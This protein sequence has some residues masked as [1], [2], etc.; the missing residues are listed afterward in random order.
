MNALVVL[1]AFLAMEPITY[2]A[3]RWVMHGP[4]MRLHRSHHLPPAGRLEA[5]DWFPVIFA[6]VVGSMMAIGFNVDGASALVWI[7]IGVT[8]YGATYALVHDG[9]IHHRLPWIGARRRRGFQPLAEA[10]ELH[11]RFGGEPYGMLLPVVPR[12]VRARAAQR[13]TAR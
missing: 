8:L 9:Y 5:N 6:L 13:A 3:H 1:G 2:A 7:G 11:H 10:H 12:A 4:G